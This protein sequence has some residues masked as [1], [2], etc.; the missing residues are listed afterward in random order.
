MAAS[1]LVELIPTPSETPPPL[2]SYSPAP[3]QSHSDMKLQS[4]SDMKG[5]RGAGS[6]LV[7]RVEQG[8]MGGGGMG[9]EKPMSCGIQATLI[10]PSGFRLKIV[11][12]NHP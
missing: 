9:Y 4:H 5:G 10:I 11:S 8:P 12:D 3:L 1:V 2:P 7:G 6:A